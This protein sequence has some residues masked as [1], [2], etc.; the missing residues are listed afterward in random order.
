MAAHSVTILI[1][2]AYKT[3]Y[4]DNAQVREQLRLALE[5]AP[6]ADELESNDWGDLASAVSDPSEWDLHGLLVD[7]LGIQIDKWKALDQPTCHEEWVKRQSES[8]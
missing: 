8:I 1:E 4:A 7:V 6:G 5:T 3:L 2:L